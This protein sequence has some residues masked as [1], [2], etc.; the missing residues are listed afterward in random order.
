MK[1]KSAHELEFE[2]RKLFKETP[3]ENAAYAEAT[4][5]QNE[6]E[7]KFQSKKWEEEWESSEC[8]CGDGTGFTVSK[9]DLL[10]P[11]WPL[12]PPILPRRPLIPKKLQFYPT[13]PLMM[14]KMLK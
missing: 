9:P 6:K 12:R 2:T 14:K 1:S 10:L 3:E 11:C 5:L 4:R 7:A 13:P 8:P